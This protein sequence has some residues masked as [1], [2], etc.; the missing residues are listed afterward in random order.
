[1]L[2]FGVGMG[3]FFQKTTSPVAAFLRVPTAV[4][5]V[6]YPWRWKKD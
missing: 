3:F 1:M 5:R 2:N 6:E 4:F